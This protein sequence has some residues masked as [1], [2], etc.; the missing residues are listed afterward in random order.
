MIINAGGLSGHS[1]PLILGKVEELCNTVKKKCLISSRIIRIQYT[2]PAW[3]WHGFMKMAIN[4]S[5]KYI[6]IRYQRT[7]TY[8]KRS[9]VFPEWHNNCAVSLKTDR[10]VERSHFTKSA[11]S[12]LIMVWFEKFEIW[13]TRDSSGYLP[14]SLWRHA[15]CDVHDDVT[16][17]RD[18]NWPSYWDKE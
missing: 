2:Y 11:V 5:K 6:F 1:R 16:R 15:R 7:C 12:Q 13:H 4:A 9:P 17:A 18:V 3:V 8:L 14:M 10:T